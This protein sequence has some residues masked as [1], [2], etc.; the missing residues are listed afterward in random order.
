MARAPGSTFTPSG[1]N[2]V[3]DR[4]ALP[5]EFALFDLRREAW[6]PSDVLT[7]ERLLSFDNTWLVWRGLLRRYG[8]P[9]WHD[10]WAK[11]LTHGGLQPAGDDEAIAAAALGAVNNRSG[12]NALAVSAARAGRAWLAG[13]PHL[14]LSLPCIWL[15]VGYRT[16]QRAAVGFMIPGAPFLG[17][18]RNRHIAWSGTSLHAYASELQRLA[19]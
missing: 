14:G 13:D 16:P 15:I 3:L 19:A 17:M 1:I 8:R 5:H 18:G 12:S 7:V 4:A 2:H 9:G 10:L 6:R 11:L